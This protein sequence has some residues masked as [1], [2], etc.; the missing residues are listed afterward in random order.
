MSGTEL[1]MKFCD[2]SVSQKTLKGIKE[3]TS[4]CIILFNSVLMAALFKTYSKPLDSFCLR[5]SS[6]SLVL[7]KAIKW[8][9]IGYTYSCKIIKSGV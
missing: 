7:S 5:N 6:Y 8:M 9:E 4:V 2:F 3:K 1:T